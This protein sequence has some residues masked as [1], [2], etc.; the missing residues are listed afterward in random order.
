MAHASTLRHV[1]VYLQT[2][3]THAQLFFAPHRMRTLLCISHESFSASLALLRR[4]RSAPFAC[5]TLQRGS[6]VAPAEVHLL[7]PVLGL[8]HGPDALL[9]LGLVTVRI[10]LATLDATLVHRPTDDSHSLRRFKFQ[11]SS[12]FLQLHRI[13]LPTCHILF[14]NT[15]M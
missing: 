13:T 8:H 15:L 9:G 1:P 5:E 7:V 14:L 12:S 11:S 6:R 3:N 10:L 4:A 2:P